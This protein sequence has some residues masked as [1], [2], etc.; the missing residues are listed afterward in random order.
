MDTPTGLAGA[1]LLAAKLRQ[2]PH[3]LRHAQDS[4]SWNPTRNQHRENCIGLLSFELDIDARPRPDKGCYQGMIEWRSVPFF[5]L[6]KPDHRA[7][8]ARHTKT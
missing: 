8:L 6:G 2:H 5:A 7:A 1:D 4:P 3:D